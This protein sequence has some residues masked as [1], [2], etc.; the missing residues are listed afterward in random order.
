LLQVFHFGDNATQ[1]GTIIYGETTKPQINLR[2]KGDEN[3]VKMSLDKLNNAVGGNRNTGK[4][5]RYVRKKGFA[6]DRSRLGVGQVAIVFIGGEPSDYENAMLQA[7]LARRQGI[8]LYI[9]S[10]NISS[11]DF[12]KKLSY[13]AS[14]PSSNFVYS[15][16]DFGIAES[17]ITLLRIHLCDGK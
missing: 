9:V 16:N 15:V 6:K 17:L 7:R 4:A 10:L 5:I 14:R 2:D 13:L 11:S 1:I 8:Y 3:Y 12:R